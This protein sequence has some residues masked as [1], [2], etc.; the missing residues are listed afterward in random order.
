MLPENEHAAFASAS[1]ARAA[2]WTAAGASG[3]ER[4]SAWPVTIHVQ[5][6]P[7]ALSPRLDVVGDDVIVCRVR[8]DG[9]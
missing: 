9:E 5:Q 6:D 1:A 4:P 7:R 2:E 8:A 3:R